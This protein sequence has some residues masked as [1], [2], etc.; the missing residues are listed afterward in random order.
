MDATL[1]ARA[2]FTLI[3]IGSSLMLFMTCVECVSERLSGAD[4]EFSLVIEYDR[5][6]D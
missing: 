6:P 3:L 2:K 1:E 5:I 4:S